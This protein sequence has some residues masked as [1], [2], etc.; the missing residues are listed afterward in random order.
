MVVRAVKPVE[1]YIEAASEGPVAV[2]WKAQTVTDGFH[3][4]IHKVSGPQ[5]GLR[6]GEHR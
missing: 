5:G 2:S 4:F 6:S 3:D 1:L